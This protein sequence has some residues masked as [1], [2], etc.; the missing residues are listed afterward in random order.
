MS[1][2]TEINAELGQ[3]T[4]VNPSITTSNKLSAGT[5]I[6]EKYEVVEPLSVSTGEAD[7]YICK[8]NDKKYVAKIYRR[9]RAVKPEVLTVL[10]SINSPYVA[11]LYDMG[12]YNNLPF[13]IL[14]YYK[15]GSLQGRQ[16]PLDELKKTIIPCINEALRVLHQNDIIHKDLKPSNIMLQDDNESIAIIDFGISSVV[17]EGNTVLVTKTGMTPEYSAPETFR[18]LFL[19]ESDYYSFGITVYEL[20]CGYTPYKNMNAEEIAQFTAVQRIPFPKDMPQELQE[21]I[22]AVTYFDITN[23]NKKENPNRRWT[24]DEVSNWCKGERQ[25]IPG[26]GVDIADDKAIP[27]YT[28]LGQRY[29]DI[30]SLITAFASNWDDG[31]KQL[32]RGLMSAFFK[33]FNPEIAGYCMDAEEEAQTAGREDII[34]W[35]LLYKIYPEL[36]GFYWAGQIYESLPALGQDMLERLRKSDRSNFTYWD[37]I[38]KN[39]LLTCYL[40]TIKLQNGD[41]AAAVSAIETAHVTGNGTQRSILMNY[42]TMAY[43]LSGEKCFHFGGKHFQNV[44]ELAAHMKG[45]CDSSY[46]EFEAFC[47]KMID[48]AGMLDVQLEAWLIALGKRR[49]LEAWRRQLS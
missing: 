2:R 44:T 38:L 23:R 9:P 47:H 15:N 16:F 12:E 49:E 6:A 36:K 35:K 26:E 13:V 48:G 19:E 32:Y 40:E 18:N 5:I 39:Q 7:L 20:F 34:F 4:I 30:P 25:V 28:F 33:N 11:S 10:K 3:S 8:Y 41:L 46:E 37:S 45:L 17:E 1:D 22:S 21:F 24:Y 42:Y 31:K 43:L 27:V 14:P 29:K